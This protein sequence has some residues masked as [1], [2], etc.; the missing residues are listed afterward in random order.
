MNI[1]IYLYHGINMINFILFIL[2]VVDVDEE[3][4]GGP[5][6][7]SL[8]ME[9][10]PVASIFSS[11]PDII[12]SDDETEAKVPSSSNGGLVTS[13]TLDRTVASSCSSRPDVVN[14]DDETQTAAILID[15]SPDTM[16]YE[17]PMRVCA[18]YN[19]CIYAIFI[20]FV[21]RIS[22]YLLS[23]DLTSLNIFLN[24]L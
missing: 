21:P 3:Y 22:V 10:G 9:P 24:I 18:S 13:P 4:R 12:I 7:D 6:A 1:A 11:R 5:I 17:M 14:P 16:H 8:A 23:I 19:V 15:D 20:F 2:Q